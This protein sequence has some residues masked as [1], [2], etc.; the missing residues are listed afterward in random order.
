[1]GIA[2][3]EVVHGR[4]SPAMKDKIRNYA[5]RNEISESDVL[6]EALRVFFNFKRV[7]K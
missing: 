7:H 6:R 3:T 4:I 1:M 2:R 5:E